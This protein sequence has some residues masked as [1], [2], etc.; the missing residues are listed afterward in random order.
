MVAVDAVDR[1]SSARLEGDLGVLSAFTAFNGE[2]LA[3]GGRRECHY[4]FLNWF[5]RPFS[6]ASSPASGT[7]LGWMVVA[8][9]L[10]CLLF[11]YRENVR[12]L[13]FKAD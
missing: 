4:F 6:G 12:G 5:L 2:E 11:F 1:P 10:E 7:A 3:R 9:G 13:A 8:L